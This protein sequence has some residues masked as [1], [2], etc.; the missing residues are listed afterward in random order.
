MM[1][2]EASPPRTSPS[3]AQRSYAACPLQRK[4]GLGTATR[5]PICQSRS[6]ATRVSS[7]QLC[8]WHRVRLK[9]SERGHLGAT[10]V[11][12]GQSD[13]RTKKRSQERGTNRAPN[14][15]VRRSLDDCSTE[16]ATQY[17]PSYGV[18]NTGAAYAV[19]VHRAAPRSGSLTPECATGP[20]PPHQH[21]HR[22]R[23]KQ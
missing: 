9:A 14:S 17:G 2:I 1:P 23:K 11:S 18:C 8:R 13:R 21:E 3:D 10:P 15:F 19:V 20:E 5:A 16:V 6:A 22:K 12:E 4:L 7:L